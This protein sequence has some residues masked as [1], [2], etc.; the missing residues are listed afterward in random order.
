LLQSFVVQEL[1]DGDQLSS[2]EMTDSST[3]LIQYFP[4]KPAWETGALFL[5]LATVGLILTFF[6]PKLG[7]ALLRFTLVGLLTLTIWFNF[8]FWSVYRLDI[9][10]VLILVLIVL[11]AVL[12]MAYGFFSEPLSRQTIKGMFDQYVPPAHIDAMLRSPEN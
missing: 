4:Y 3:E 11:L 10:L 5:I 8:Q 7:P 12:N 2:G 6:L 9:S 1:E